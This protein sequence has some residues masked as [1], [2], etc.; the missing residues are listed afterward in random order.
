MEDAEACARRT[1]NLIAKR[2]PPPLF[3]VVIFLS[4]LTLAALAL[5]YWGGFKEE[6]RNS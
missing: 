1:R 2:R 5:I 3:N 6:S 4:V